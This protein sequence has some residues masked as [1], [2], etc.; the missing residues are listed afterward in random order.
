ME[1]IDADEME[2]FQRLSDQ[3]QP[4]IQVR[5][6]WLLRENAQ[7][8]KVFRVLCSEISCQ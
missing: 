1:S 2:T 7:S 6:V 5:P 3:Y 4:D 8:L